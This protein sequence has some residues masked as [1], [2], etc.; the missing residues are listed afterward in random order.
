M[1]ALT[2][3]LVHFGILSSIF[4]FNQTRNPDMIAMLL[5]I[6]G[7]AILYII[8]YIITEGLLSEIIGGIII[9][10]ILIGAS[11]L[12]PPLA[13]ILMLWVFINILISIKSIFD[14]LPSLLISILLFGT[15]S[16]KSILHTTDAENMG[17]ASVYAISSFLYSMRLSKLPLKH[18]I[19]KLSTM[20]VSAPIIVLTTISVTSGLRNLFKTNIVNVTGKIKTPQTVSSHVRGG[21]LVDSY[22]RNVTKT[23]TTSV[24]NHTV[25]TGAVSISAAG[26]ISDSVAS[27]D[28]NQDKEAQEDSAKQ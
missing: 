20:F 19:M 23:V 24:T 9:T 13:I 12:F 2:N 6:M 8:F 16:H 7:G 5:A 22:T 28:K 17:F 18:G 21:T 15:I 11:T 25:G 27:K 4:V 3:F 26:S 1:I 10:M 14:L